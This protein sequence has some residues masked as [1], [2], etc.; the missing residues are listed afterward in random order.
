MNVHGRWRLIAQRIQLNLFKRR[1]LA[2]I[3]L[4]QARLA[5]QPLFLQL[6]A[7][8]HKRGVDLVQKHSALLDEDVAGRNQR[9][10]FGLRC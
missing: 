9:T 4:E 3:Q 8:P 2:H 10:E 7:A 6:G 5:G 1:E